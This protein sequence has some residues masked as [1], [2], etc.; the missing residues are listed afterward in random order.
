[1]RRA[2]FSLILLAILAFGWLAGKGWMDARAD[3]PGLAKRADAL[4]AQGKGWQ[5]LGPERSRWLLAVE[6][7]T[8]LSHKGIDLTTPGA[9]ITTVTQ[10]LAKRVGFEQEFKP[11]IAKLR[12]TAY[13]MSLEN[14]LSKEQIIA[15]WLDT[16]EMGQGPDGW[17]TGFEAAAIAQFGAEPRA[18]SDDEFLTLVAVLIAPARLPM[19]PDNAETA[20][21]L[22]RIKLL[23]AQECAPLDNSDVW[24]EGCAG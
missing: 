16:A 4:I 6:D 23:I 22:S 12:Q 11:G 10:S 8:F 5:M 1:M 9:G 20:E 17:I 24:L 18:I 2:V 21:R 19:N 7:P 14:E 13:A 15:L 3:A